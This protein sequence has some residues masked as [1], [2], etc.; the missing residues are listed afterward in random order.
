MADPIF[1]AAATD[2]KEPYPITGYVPSKFLVRN[3]AY[4]V[5][6]IPAQLVYL[7]PHYLNPRVS[8]FDQVA[9]GGL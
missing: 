7:K 6:P 2:Q 5:D 9:S 4:G 8:Y 3:G 1:Y